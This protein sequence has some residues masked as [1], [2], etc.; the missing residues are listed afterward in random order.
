LKVRITVKWV[1]GL[2]FDLLF[3]RIVATDDIHSKG[4]VEAP[5]AQGG[6]AD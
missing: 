6:Q 5:S 3:T 4:W 1:N 2:E